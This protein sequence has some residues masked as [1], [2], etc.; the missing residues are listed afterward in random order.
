MSCTIYW[1]VTRQI[2][3]PY[4]TRMWT[5]Y[6]FETAAEKNGN[7][8]RSFVRPFV[9]WNNRWGPCLFRLEWGCALCPL[10]VLWSLQGG[11]WSRTCRFVLFCLWKHF[12]FH[13]SLSQISRQPKHCTES[14]SSNLSE[15]VL[16]IYL[17]IQL[18]RILVTAQR[19][20]V[21]SYWIFH[22]GS[23]TL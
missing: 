10:K 12:I 21:V 3:L 1:Y 18:C 16:S 11:G 17:F 15:T 6:A 19:F 20:F 14:G 2:C 8:F 23:W 5:D 9:L 22:C 7:C 4:E 13:S